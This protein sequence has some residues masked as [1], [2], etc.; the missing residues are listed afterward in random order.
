MKAKS[1]AILGCNPIAFPWGYD[2]E[3]ERCAA[4]K[5]ALLNRITTL[6]SESMTV[7]YVVLDSG[8]GLY[9]AEMIADLCE[10]DPAIRLICVVPYETQATKWTPELRDRYFNVQARCSDV[11]IV[12][13]EEDQA[14]ELRAM[15]EA[16]NRAA[17]VV[18]ATGA[19]DLYVLVV[20][21]YAK[22]LKR[23]VIILDTKKL[24]FH[25]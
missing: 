12:S 7:Y 2:E 24:Q 3:D 9:S 17:T 13:R 16:I 19:D 23:D 6:R 11:L 5:L 8:A 1:C 18:L 15:L 14:R 25:G 10:N 20:Q 21:Q 22:Q 4:L